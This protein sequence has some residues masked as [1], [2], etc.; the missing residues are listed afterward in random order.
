VSRDR[1]VVT[2][3]SR[4]SPRSRGIVAICAIN[5]LITNTLVHVL[6]FMSIH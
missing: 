5:V 3:S 1:V 4:L 2:F 6:L